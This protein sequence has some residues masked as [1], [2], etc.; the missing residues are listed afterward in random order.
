MSVIEV[1][2][3]VVR[4][5]DRQGFYMNALL[6]RSGARKKAVRDF[7]TYQQIMA[8]RQSMINAQAQKTNQQPA[9]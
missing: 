1:Q 7:Q 2:R 5:M 9:Q 4:K 8:Y 6:S 3:D